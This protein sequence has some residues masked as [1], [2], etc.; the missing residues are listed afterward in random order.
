MH[1]GVA[2]SLRIE[3]DKLSV[4][5]A[6]HMEEVSCLPCLL[7]RHSCHVPGTRCRVH[8]DQAGTQA[9]QVRVGVVNGIPG[10]WHG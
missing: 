6:G 4:E 3:P 5:A 1:C 7:M 10:K 9:E 2:A 8:R